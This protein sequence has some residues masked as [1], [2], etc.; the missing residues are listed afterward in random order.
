MLVKE[1]YPIFGP[2]SP[3]PV[4]FFLMLEAELFPIY[5]NIVFKKCDFLSTLTH[6]LQLKTKQSKNIMGSNDGIK[7]S[8]LSGSYTN[9]RTQLT[10]GI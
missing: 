7:L 3:N 4:Y 6:T 2:M 8:S 9:L 10:V 1:R 5:K